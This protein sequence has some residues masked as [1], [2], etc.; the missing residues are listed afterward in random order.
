MTRARASTV[1]AL[2]ASAASIAATATGHVAT[3]VVLLG[4]GILA[5]SAVAR[6]NWFRRP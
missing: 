4:V 1:V 3:A 2:I 5:A 6:A